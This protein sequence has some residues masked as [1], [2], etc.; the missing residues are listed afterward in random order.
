MQGEKKMRVE[1]GR[2]AVGLEGAKGN[3]STELGNEQAP[4]RGPPLTLSPL[5]ERS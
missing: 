2:K 1:L 5:Q 3:E 4:L